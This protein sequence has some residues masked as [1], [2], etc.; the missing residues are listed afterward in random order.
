MFE[1]KQMLHISMWD[2][3][4]CEY[5][6]QRGFSKLGFTNNKMYRIMRQLFYV[7]NYHDWTLAL[8]FIKHMAVQY[9]VLPQILFSFEWP[10][11]FFYTSSHS[12]KQTIYVF[13]VMGT[14]AIKVVTNNVFNLQQPI[15][16]PI[17]SS[18]AIKLNEANEPTY[19]IFAFLTAKY[20]DVAT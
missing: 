19:C 16:L 13:Q 6:Y 15:C 5:F 3:F 9:Y 10:N 11:W 2:I 7:Q 4:L 17:T 8:F 1:V 12:L 20:T 18:H 14:F